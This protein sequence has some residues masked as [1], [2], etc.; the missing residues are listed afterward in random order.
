MSNHLKGMLIL[1]GINL[2]ILDAIPV[3]SWIDE[4]ATLGVWAFP[5]IWCMIYSW[6]GVILHMVSVLCNCMRPVLIST[7][8][9]T[10]VGVIIFL[11]KALSTGNTFM[12]ILESG[13]FIPIVCAAFGIAIGKIL[14]IIKK[15]LVY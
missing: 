13:I 4:P 3:F 11:W 7:V 10:A 6:A 12:E 15:K 2:I 1:V 9:G 5:V 14:G 8:G